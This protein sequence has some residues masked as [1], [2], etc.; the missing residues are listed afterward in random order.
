M[1]HRGQSNDGRGEC[2]V[3]K[4]LRWTRTEVDPNKPLGI[5]CYNVESAI[6]DIK[7]RRLK[8]TD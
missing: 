2:V 8:N 7:L 5:C 4:F 6:K 1:A 3:W